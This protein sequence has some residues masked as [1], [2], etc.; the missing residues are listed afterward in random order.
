MFREHA[1]RRV[2]TVAI[3]IILVVLASADALSSVDSMSSF[4]WVVSIGAISAVVLRRRCP[5]VAF[6]IVLP[7]LYFAWSGVAAMIILYTLA[8][9]HRS[10]AVLCVC[11][12]IAIIAFQPMSPSAITSSSPVEFLYTLLY[13]IGPLAIGLL[14]S[15]RE[16]NERQLR[17]LREF[18][19]KD[20]Q[21]AVQQALQ[22]ERATLA[23]DM[24]DI[25]SNQ[26]S[27]I[28]VQAGALQVSNNDESVR[29]VAQLIRQLSV[30]TLNDLRSLLGILRSDAVGL[31]MDCTSPPHSAVKGTTQEL[32]ALVELNEI[33]CE[34][35]IDLPDDVDPDV[36]RALYRTLQ[37]GLT[38]VRKHAPDTRVIINI[39]F[40][41]AELRLLIRN[42]LKTPNSHAPKLPSGNFGLLG[43]AE[44]IEAL[45]GQFTSGPTDDGW[46]E[47]TAVIPRSAGYRISALSADDGELDS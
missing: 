14:V 41:E 21:Q 11:A 6:I 33:S 43:L 18:R 13:V 2:T 26:V 36:G 20:Q 22:A 35:T 34:L 23:R 40:T 45:N 16:D 4:D 10:R 39:S 46:F 42:R 15:A 47:V 1:S 25:V 7:G 27:L 37:E 3:E 31:R 30:S 5:I 38:N 24:H 17:E 19:E 29:R 9:K 28:A 12:L 44:R 8:R 32:A